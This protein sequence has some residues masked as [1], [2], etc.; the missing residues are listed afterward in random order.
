MEYLY[1]TMCGQ[2][3]SEIDKVI[4]VVSVD[5]AKSAKRWDPA[6]V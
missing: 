3:M 6:K 4:D 5:N 2:L 1:N